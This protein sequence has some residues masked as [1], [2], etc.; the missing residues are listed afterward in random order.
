MKLEISSQKL[1]L[2]QVLI[3][4]LKIILSEFSES[5]KDKNYMLFRKEVENYF[6]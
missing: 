6:I 1:S 4:K 5:I 3:L 2:R